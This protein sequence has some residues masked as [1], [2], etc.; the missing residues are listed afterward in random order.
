[1]WT[2]TPTSGKE[3]KVLFTDGELASKLDNDLIDNVV[4]EAVVALRSSQHDTL[5][6]LAELGKVKKTL[7]TVGD[8]LIRI[9]RT[10][11]LSSVAAAW[12]EGRYAWRTILYD[13]QSIDKALKHLDKESGFWETRKG[14]S[15]TIEDSWDGQYTNTGNLLGCTTELSYNISYRGI[16]RGTV[17]TPSFGG[18]LLVTG[19]EL[20]PFS[21]ILDWFLDLGTKIQLFSSALGNPNDTSHYGI[22][23]H[24]TGKSNA[25]VITP[26]SYSGSGYYVF[27]KSSATATFEAE[28]VLRAPYTP[29]YIPNWVLNF[30]TSKLRDITALLAQSIK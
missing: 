25:Y 29:S 22:R 19:Y 17:K 10:G 3:G 1:M 2:F 26:D 28:L 7:L 23:V 18:D 5:T 15:A 30:D 8:S 13:L 9:L 21:W 6:F 4:A 27:N 14:N 16:A 20:V 12:L 11:S 24:A